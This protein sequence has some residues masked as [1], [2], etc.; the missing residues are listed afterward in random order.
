MDTD[1]FSQVSRLSRSKKHKEVNDEEK[2][3]ENT[4]NGRAWVG[5]FPQDFSARDD[6][7]LDEVY[8]ADPSAVLLVLAWSSRK[9]IPS[10]E[11][12]ALLLDLETLPPAEQVR[13]W[14]AAC[15]QEG[16]QPWRVLCR[17][18]AL[19]GE[20]CTLCAHLCTRH[21]A[22][23]NERR[24]FHSACDLG[25]LILEHGRGTG[26]LWLSPPECRG[27]ERWVPGPHR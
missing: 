4:E 13:R 24:Q 21:E 12:A 5:A 7:D 22:I 6:G 23:G 20:D 18:A 17:P 16:I 26:R 2:I 3:K 9:E 15:L 8:P 11:R 14:P 27:Y 19:S 10:D 1:D 25:Y